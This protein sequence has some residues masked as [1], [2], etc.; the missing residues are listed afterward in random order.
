MASFSFLR[1]VFKFESNKSKYNTYSTINLTV[2]DFIPT[3]RDLI[4]VKTYSVGPFVHPNL[5]S[6]IPD[7]NWTKIT[8]KQGKI[9]LITKNNKYGMRTV[10]IIKMTKN[11]CRSKQHFEGNANVLAKY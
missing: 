5:R 1:V 2:N 10:N 8:C 3:K 11:Y 7:N 6:K 9:I 4:E